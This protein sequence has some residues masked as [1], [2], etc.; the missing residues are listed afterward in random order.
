MSDLG[1]ILGSILASVTQARRIADEETVAVAQYYKSTD[2]LQGMS[3]PRVRIPEIE[4]DLPV[5]VESFDEGREA[6]ARSRSEIQ[7]RVRDQLDVICREVGV[8]LPKKFLGRFAAELGRRLKDEGE[9]S[10]P[11]NT[12]VEAAEAAFRGA[13]EA[14]PLEGRFT[15]EQAN[16]VR[17]AL[18]H[19]VEREAHEKPPVPLSYFDVSVLT[20]DIKAR[21][22]PDN[23]ARLKISLQEEGL[24][25]TRIEQPD[26]TTR[27]I[28]V[29]E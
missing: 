9:G 29:P 13:R 20:G 4:V 12:L 5:L 17:E 21:G 10:V 8:R 24:E 22:G 2:L 1:K 26:G 14:D 3:L 27:D 7:T 19:R 6:P 18:R 16:A 15:V 11:A 23:V 28:L 25:W